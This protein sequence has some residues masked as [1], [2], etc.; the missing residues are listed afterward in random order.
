MLG[1]LSMILARTPRA[2]ELFAR[3]QL[4]TSSLTLNLGT[5]AEG[6]GR[7]EGGQRRRN[8]WAV[9]EGAAQEARADVPRGAAFVLG[10]VA[11]DRAAQ[12]VVLGA[13]VSVPRPLPD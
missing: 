2:T 4:L 13:L 11:M 5:W 12:H 10:A 3:L 9:R 8:G 7:G 6:E 1:M